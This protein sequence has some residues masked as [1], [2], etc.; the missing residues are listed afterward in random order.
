M[1]D[2]PAKAISTKLE[3]VFQRIYTQRM[4]D[5]PMVNNKLQ[6]HAI[7][8]QL[9]NGHFIGV[10]STPWFMNLILLPGDDTDW[11]DQ[12]ELSSQTHTFP[13]DRYEFITAY[14]PEL[15]QYQMCSLFSPMFA[16]A[17]DETAVQTA[18]LIMRELMNAEH[19]DQQNKQHHGEPKNMNS[20]SNPS[21]TRHHVD[22]TNKRTGISANMEKP[23][24]RRQLLRGIFNDPGRGERKN[25]P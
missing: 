14:E 10:L 21:A 15:D 25:S 16:F 2:N 18:K 6:V 19:K 4:S 13:S 17:D 22:D 24:S 20:A 3:T 8:F 23:V 1:S 7:D 9:W 5:M 11:S 12:H